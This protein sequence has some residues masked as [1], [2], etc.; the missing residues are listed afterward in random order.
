MEARLA[1]L[2]TTHAAYAKTAATP[3]EEKSCLDTVDM[4]DKAI[5]I[6]QRRKIGML[7]NRRQQLM[8][9]KA[10]LQ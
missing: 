4:R 2:E 3:Q 1:E 5:T 8:Q 9:E 6:P 7:K 10:R